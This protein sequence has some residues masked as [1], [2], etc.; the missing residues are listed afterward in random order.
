M[1]SHCSTRKYVNSNERKIGSRKQKRNACRGQY[2]PGASAGTG[3]NGAIPE[4]MRRISFGGNSHSSNHTSISKLRISLHPSSDSSNDVP[5]CKWFLETV[6]LVQ[7]MSSTRDDHRMEWKSD[8]TRK[9]KNPRSSFL[10]QV[11]PSLQNRWAILD[12]NTLL[13]LTGEDNEAQVT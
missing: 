1:G 10:T 5:P 13:M 12:N 3:R 9:E 2:T 6:Q 8:T 4:P 11:F 7:N